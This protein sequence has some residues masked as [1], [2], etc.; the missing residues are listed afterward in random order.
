VPIVPVLGALVAAAW[1]KVAHDPH[2]SAIGAFA[3]I[4][5]AAAISAEMLL[6][7]ARS[8]ADVARQQL[9]SAL[10]VRSRVVRGDVTLEIG[11]ADVKPGETVLV[12]AGE[13]VGVDGVVSAGEA[14]VV[15]WLGSESRVTKRD[16]DAVVAG[17]R[18]V[19]GRLRL[20]TTWAGAD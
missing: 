15:P 4:A 6:A 11:A 8:T 16:G 18:V 12:D 9:A 17:A 2:A 5:A 14:T 13:V 19:E 3:G 20:T 7:R 10:S 1:S